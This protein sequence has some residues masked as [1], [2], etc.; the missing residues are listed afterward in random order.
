MHCTVTRLV[1][2]WAA[3]V[4][5][6]SLTVAPGFAQLTSGD[7]VGTVL[8]PTGAVVP[9]VTITATNSATG[10]KSTTTTTDT[11]QY[12]LPNLPVG[13][14]DLSAS[15][16]GFSTATIKNVAVTL[17]KVATA[18]ITLQV[19]QMTQTV[20]VQE[21]ATTI[22]TT[23]AQVQNTFTTKEAQDLP[24]ASV[25]LGVLN[26]SLLASGVASS[27]GVGAGT[28]PSVGG[29]RPRN[30]NFT[31]E[32]IDNNSKSVTGPLAYIPNDAVAEFTVLQNQF[33]A[34]YGHSSGGQF[35]QIMKSGANE[36]HGSLYDYL[37]NRNLNAVNQSLANQDIRSNPR[38][39][40]NRLGATIGGPIKRNKLFFFGNYEYNPIGQAAS[41]ASPILVPTAQG[42]NQLASIPG[43]YPVNLNIFKQYT[44][45]APS[46]TCVAG[47]KGNPCPVVAGV[48]ISA[49]ILPI[50]SPNFS[51]GYAGV[52]SVDYT[53][54]DKDQLRVRFIYNKTSFIDTASA[55]PSFYLQVPTTSYVLTLT[56]YHNFSPTLTNEFR[57]GYN[58][59]NNTT[60]AGDFKWPGLD[61]FP[62]VDIDELN[63]SNFG[64]DG[65]APQF[66][67]QN[68]Y[69]VTDNV[70]WTTGNHTFKF[71]FDGRKFISPQSFTQRAR[72]EYDYTTLERFLLDLNPDA[73]SERSLGNVIYYGDQIALY[74]Y[75]NDSW[76]IRPN[77][78]L[79]LGVRYEFTSVPYSQRL[80]PLNAIANVPGVLVFQ[81]PTA[82]YKNFAP[83]LGIAYSP[84]T[85][86]RT[87]IRAGFG[88]A[89]DVL[90]DNIGILSL[91]PQLSTTIDTDLSVD[92][93]NFLKTGGIPP[94]AQATGELTRADAIAGT[95]NYIPNQKLPYSI[96]WNFGVQHVFANDFTFEARYLGTRGVHLNVQER[97]NVQPRVDL[98]HYLPTYTQ[99]PDAATLAAL[100]F[101]LG[102]LNK[103]PRITSQF[104]AA[105]FK[106][107]IVE[108]SPIG[109]STYHGLALQLDKRFSHGLQF[110]GAYT[111][112]HLID[113]STADFFT[114]YLT[115]RRPQDFQN[116]RADRGTSALDR[117]HR[118]TFTGI[119]DV[120]W[121][122]HGNWFMKNLV[123]NW[124]IAPIYT[125]ESPEYAD[126]QSGVD[127]N[128]NGDSAGDRAFVNV[129]G[130]KGTGSGVT[131]VGRNGQS[132]KAGNADIVAYVVNNPNA[133]YYQ[134]GLGALPTGLRGTAGRN[135]IATRPINN[136]DA[137]F[138]K[139]FNFTERMRVELGGQFFNLFNH[140]QFIPGLLNQVNSI[141][142][143]GSGIRSYLNPAN[144][145]FNNPELAFGSN[146]RSIQVIAK[147]MF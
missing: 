28:G 66:T 79:N 84:G 91:P 80:Q 125:Y 58:R 34:E 109:N 130:V 60:P 74:P 107:N 73:L 119:Y 67:I 100:P 26:L 110:R 19:G 16:S 43:I 117:R 141:G 41:P 142:Q 33:S 139:R 102:D 59:Y 1:L 30:N 51:N 81:K 143:T 3:L 123:G 145:A 52:A 68:L 131:P 136:W 69:Q 115:P 38:Y 138:L 24:T 54:S 75:A 25:G 77:F 20:E 146:P 11:G 83:R 124:E 61:V 134:A 72:G 56:E 9:N 92:T 14:Y 8:D 87:S 111:W 137:T 31:V 50:A 32:G 5:V 108:F 101:T 57:L 129:S 23:T 22:D 47:S 126:V 113:D 112:S 44:P 10:V 40:N 15:A 95:A 62:T 17:N 135:T 82:Q 140:P 96:Q 36:F 128:L 4:A 65:N 105:G 35:N 7:L 13:T 27:G 104:L 103:R 70:S 121:F 90:Y 88:M 144:G 53:M 86:G 18:N 39:D 55:L 93:P 29:Q 63:L 85:S 133:Q 132:L 89:Y 46:Q 122:K 94:N 48:P 118:F 97:V 21:A 64:P 120:P 99:Q 12:R 76:K 42:Y 6:L 127:S 116:L 71:G 2:L 98:Q 147:F 37:Q 49:G 114:T 45:P 78:T 106:N